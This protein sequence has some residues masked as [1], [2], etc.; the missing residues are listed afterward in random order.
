[1]FTRTGV[2]HLMSISGLHVTMMSA[3]MFTLVHALW[4]RSARLVLRLPARRAAV[5]AGFIAALAYAGIAGFAVPAQRTVYM[6]AVVACALWL[7]IMESASVVL[8]VALLAQSATYLQTLYPYLPSPPA[9]V[10]TILKKYSGR[11]EDP[12]V[13]ISRER[14]VMPTQ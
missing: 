12:G 2:N 13:R 3:L 7:G 10:S 4:R 11:I 8:C 9:A 14:V 5:V 6:L 1:M